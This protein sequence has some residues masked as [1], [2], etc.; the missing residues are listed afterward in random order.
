M[1]EPV[2]VSHANAM[3][4]QRESGEPH[5]VALDSLPVPTRPHHSANLL[6][7]SLPGGNLGSRANFLIANAM[8]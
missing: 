3:P 8:L 4:D 6:R 2:T 7:H 1:T 5:F